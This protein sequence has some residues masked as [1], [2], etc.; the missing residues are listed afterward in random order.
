MRK[1]KVLLLLSIVFLMVACQS[2]E[3]TK[4]TPLPQPTSDPL[5]GK[6]VGS[7]NSIEKINRRGLLVYLG[8]IIIGPDGFIAGALDTKNSKSTIVDEE[9]GSFVLTNIEP[10]EYSLIIYEVEAGGKALLDSSGNVKIVTVRSGEETNVGI[11]D[12]DKMNRE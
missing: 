11:L 2:I 4:T 5:K 12:L 3:G 10:G 7:V 1:I 6:V 8:S 9:T